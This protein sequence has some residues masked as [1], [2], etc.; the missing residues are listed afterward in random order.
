MKARAIAFTRVV[1]VLLVVIG[2]SLRAFAADAAEPPTSYTLTAW[3]TEKGLPPGDVLAMTQDLDGYLWIG[4]TGGLVRF[5]G[6]QFASWGA[7]GEPALPAK[8]VPALIGSHDGSLWI[9]FGNAGGVSRFRDG[10]LVNYSERD[11]LPRGAIA[12]LVED[13]HGTIWAGGSGG[14]SR[15]VDDRWELVGPAAGLPGDDVFSLYEDRNGTLWVGAAGGVYRGQSSEFELIDDTSKYA[16]GL[17]EDDAGA[18]WVTDLHRIVK[19][20]KALD[21]PHLPAAVRVPSA[22]W[23]LL[24][25]R[26][27]SLWVASW[28]SGLLRIRNHGAAQSVVERFSYENKIAGSPRSLFEDQ[29]GNIWVGMRGGGL[30]R[31]SEA[32]VRNDIPLDGLTPDGVRALSASGDGSVWVATE[33]NLHRFSAR[34]RKVFS[35]PQTLALH[36]DTAGTVWAATTQGVV[37]VVNDRLVPLALP[38][39]MRWDRIASITTDSAGALWLCRNDQGLWRWDQGKFSR[40]DDVPEVSAKPCSFTYTDRRDRVW[41]GF[42]AGGVALYE[43]GQFHVYDEH[44]GLAGGRVAAI[45]EDRKGAV[46]IS[47]AAGL[48]RVQNGRVT[49]V[50]AEN[51]PFSSVVPSLLE[52][53]DGYLWMGVNSGSSLVRFNPS[54]LDKVAANRAYE[55]EYSV[56]DISDGLPGDLQWLSRPAAVR[57][58]DGRL[59]FATRDGVSLID[60]QLLPRGRRPAPPRVDRVTAD[61]RLLASAPGVSLPARTST[62]QVDYGA[63]SLSAASK[64]RF[65]YM[66]EGQNSAWVD[67]GSR[68]QAVFTAIQPGHYRFRVSATN[69]GR[70]TE[71]AAWDFSVAPPFYR[72]NRF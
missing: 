43:G 63:L 53:N 13:R 67:A 15:F 24:H 11:G 50:T 48:S 47:A 14:L 38:Q 23:R 70:W 5:D 25:D 59:W 21:A 19:K 9:G 8:S 40:F 26:H 45:Y 68:R 32:V 10:R 31:I 51:G 37:R 30:L 52:D 69:D 28:G 20:V 33:H 1:L 46:W 55:I 16:W 6:F 22:G 12:A 62:L 60:P 18:M 27:G 49:T 61:G 41:V 39:G 42:V 56:Y 54:E 72:T 71:A 66:L 2:S 57:G 29:D 4:T 58:G 35:L 34:A 3:T 44:A 64:L 36:T 65:R 7:H 17:A